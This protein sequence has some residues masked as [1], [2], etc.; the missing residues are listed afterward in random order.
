M[1][2]AGFKLRVVGNLRRCKANAND[3]DSGKKDNEAM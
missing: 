1:L 2:F 3:N